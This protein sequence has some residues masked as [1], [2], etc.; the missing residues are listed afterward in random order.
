M[1]GNNLRWMVVFAV[2]GL[3]SGCSKVGPDDG[4]GGSGGSTVTG[5]VPLGGA[6]GRGG[7][8]VAG[9][10]GQGNAG[11]GEE[12]SC[13]KSLFAG[14]PTIPGTCSAR[15]VG[16]AGSGGNPSGKICYASGTTVITDPYVGCTGTVGQSNYSGKVYRPDGSFCYSYSHDCACGSACATGTTTF[17]DA[18]GT[19][20][21]THQVTA[22]TSTLTCAN[23]DVCPNPTPGAGGRSGSY[24]N[25]Y[26]YAPGFQCVVDGN[27]P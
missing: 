5:D 14:C 23:G 3:F 8:A 9:S 13:L 10:G 20:V 18:A 21:A 24:P 22:T 26:P 15:D 27:C 1:I 2:V 7:N 25:C 11:F 16:V 6:G 12:F 17:F 19:L 4:R